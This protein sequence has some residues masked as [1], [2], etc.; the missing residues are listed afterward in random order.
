M[1]EQRSPKPW[2]VGSNPARPVVNSMETEKQNFIGSIRKF[3][4]EVISELKKVSW[5][6]R[7]DL[8]DSTWVVIVSSAILGLFIGVVDF[9]LSR[10]M[11]F[12]IK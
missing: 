1:V 2:V 7:K 10:V 8:L 11:T 9:V 4:A 6:T 5:T 3:F 12:L